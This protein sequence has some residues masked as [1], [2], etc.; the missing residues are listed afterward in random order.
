MS[1][2]HRAHQDL[3]AII[4]PVSPFR[5]NC[6]LLFDKR[7]KCG[8]LIDPGAELPRILD[9]IKEHDL[10]IEAIWLTHGHV[11]H[12][13]AAMAAKRALGVEIY[14]SHKADKVL[15][16]VLPQTADRYQWPDDVEA[17]IPDHWLEEGDKV[18]C[19]GHEFEVFHTP[20]HAPGHVIY[21]CRP[22]KL[23]IMGDVLF[24]GSVGRTDL[25]YA[26]HEDLMRSLKEKVLPLGDDVVFICGH[27][28]GST[29]GREKLENPFLHDLW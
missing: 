20:G 16:D 12:A 3:Q 29:I 14:G 19:G 6:T 26:S 25:P 4:L 10:K 27:G 18:M 17:C 13:A 23:A 7:S 8:V 22:A 28:R 11:D 9:A 21:F 2:H 15:M 1:D 24:R 5:Q